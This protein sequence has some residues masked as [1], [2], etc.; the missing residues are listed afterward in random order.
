MQWHVERKNEFYYKKARELGY[1]SRS[2]FK[3]LEIQEKFHIIKRG[4]KILDLGAAP[5]GWSQVA[6]NIAGES[7]FVTGVDIQ[8][9]PNI[10]NNFQFILADITKESSENKISKLCKKFNVVLSDTSPGTTGIKD[11]DVGISEALA[12]RSLH[13]ATVFLKS[14][15]NFTCKIFQGKEFVTFSNEA[16]KYFEKVHNFKPKASDKESR[17]IYVVCTNLKEHVQHDSE[18]QQAA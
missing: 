3:L 4:D 13:L 17:E 1:R 7:G 10:G 16:K 9:A 18:K 12:F 6:A 14:G 2:A 5:G 11:I 15:G 8:P